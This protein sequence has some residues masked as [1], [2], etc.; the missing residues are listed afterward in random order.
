MRREN[1]VVGWI[2]KSALDNDK[3]GSER[4]ARE[5][6]GLHENDPRSLTERQLRSCGNVRQGYGYVTI[7]CSVVELRLEIV[8]KWKRRLHR[9]HGDLRYKEPSRKLGVEIKR[10]K[11][12]ALR[13]SAASP[14]ISNSSYWKPA[15]RD[16]RTTESRFICFPL[17][18]FFRPRGDV[19]GEPHSKLSRDCTP[20]THRCLG[21]TASPAK[22]RL[23]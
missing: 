13:H 3:T 21:T 9:C 12:P 8:W 19:N 4:I 20:E 23:R 2:N 7:A 18:C 11:Q 1:C 10:E 6:E 15:H 22:T 17:C 5:N 14:A 16:A